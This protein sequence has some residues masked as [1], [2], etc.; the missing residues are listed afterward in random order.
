MKPSC[1]HVPQMLSRKTLT[2][3]PNNWSLSYYGT[4]VSV[5]PFSYYQAYI[6]QSTYDSNT[7]YCQLENYAVSV[8]L[9]GAGVLIS[10][11]FMSLLRSRIAGWLQNEG[12][13]QH[14][15]G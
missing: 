5:R 13:R 15:L 7:D 6:T 1:G 12:K 10:S 11:V 8:I 14:A 9:M 2:R 3:L 4:D